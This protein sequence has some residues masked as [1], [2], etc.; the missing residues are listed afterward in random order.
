LLHGKPWK[1]L[2]IRTG[3]IRTCDLKSLFH[4]HLS[5]IVAALEQNS[6]VELDRQKVQIIF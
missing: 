2:L 3:N 4:A 6:L 5:A 1:L